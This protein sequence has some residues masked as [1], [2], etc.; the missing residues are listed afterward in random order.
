MST[1]Q[2]TKQLEVYTDKEINELAEWA[3]SLTIAQLMFL[4]DSYE[5]LNQIR[6][7]EIG[8]STYVQ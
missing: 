5:A 2:E 8:G 7:H 6:A 3:D 1:K 4:K